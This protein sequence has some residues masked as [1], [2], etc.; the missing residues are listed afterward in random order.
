MRPDVVLHEEGLDG[1]T[2]D[3]AV[4]TTAEADLLIVGGTSLVVYPAAS[5]LNYYHGKHLALINLSETGADRRA[6]LVI[7]KPIGEVV[8]ALE[9][10]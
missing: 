10:S 9:L 5:F 3:G 4:G 7:R 1:E 8:S 6:N 2:V